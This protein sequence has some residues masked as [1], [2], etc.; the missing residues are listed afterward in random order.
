MGRDASRSL[1]SKV[2]CIVSFYSEYTRALT[3]ENLWQDENAARYMLRIAK[4]AE[5]ASN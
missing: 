2:L 1:F 5:L 4:E 3:F